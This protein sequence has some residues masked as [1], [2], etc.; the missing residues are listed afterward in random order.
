MPEA[1]RA[2]GHPQPPRAPETRTP[3][4]ESWFGEMPA[5][6]GED[7]VPTS[8]P[9]AKAGGKPPLAV[10]ELGP[11]VLDSAWVEPSTRF[12]EQQLPDGVAGPRPAFQRI[13][14]AFVAARAALGVLLVLSQISLALFSNATPALSALFLSIGYAAFTITQWLLPARLSEPAVQG[15]LR[16][17]EWVAT[18][19]L[20]L[21]AFGVLH[22]LS[23]AAPAYAALF[24]LPVL[25]AGVLT[26]RLPAMAVAA[27]VSIVLLGSAGLEVARGG[28]GTVLITQAGLVGGGFF[29]IAV[30]AGELAGRLAREELAARSTLAM[31]RQQAQLNRLV[32]DEMQEGVLVVDR[33]G[34]V[35]A[36]NPAA[37]QLLR[38]SRVNRAAAPF[39]LR[40]VPAWEP[41]VNAVERAFSEGTWPVGGRDVTL[42]F[43]A[44]EGENASSRNLRLRMRFTRRRHATSI[45]ELCV[46]L[47]EDAR[48]VQ[49]RARQEK[50]AAMGRVSA[51]IAHEIRNPLAAIA[52]ANALLHEDMADPALR[53][54]TQMVSDN[55][56]RLKRIVDDVLE[57]APREK[58]DAPVIDLSTTVA[59]TC[60][61]WA[62][63][64][65]LAAD[66]TSPL[67]MDPG[68]EIG[69]VRF[70]PDHLRRVLVNLLDNALRHSSQQPGCVRVR[71]RKQGNSGLALSVGSDGAP[72]SQDVEPYLF[73][74]FFSTRSR[75]TGL[76]LYI[77]RE[78]CE[79][80]G[81]TIE[82]RPRNAD[83]RHRNVFQ[84]TMPRLPLLPGQSPS[85]SPL[86]P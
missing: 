5:P 15:R 41:M 85:P 76:G 28:E 39:L 25:M 8:T 71:I 36:A 7:D 46:L 42:Q 11:D 52:Q 1:T 80:Y 18:I 81:A 34:R 79:R 37:L 63:T 64:A 68:R 14:R 10:D 45:E 56:E 59:T 12:L 35:R 32:I 22:S 51:G 82:Y 6:V 53:R 83:K 84:V 23:G 62:R 55:V 20:D 69:G 61:E 21:V 73:E 2:A 66:D 4:R 49:A 26:A 30:L 58:F 27:G 16:R 13:Y 72:I 44:R 60:S 75:G 17:R 3:N 50:L 57:V 40:G 31:A 38:A 65:G 19:G 48:A 70:E 29:L 43:D 67:E 24:V 74:P 86:D 9:S 54:L 47:I 77:C 33:G 78:L